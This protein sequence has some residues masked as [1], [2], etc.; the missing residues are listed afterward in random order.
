MFSQQREYLME[1]ILPHKFQV[2]Q[3]LEEDD[4][5]KITSE[6]LFNMKEN[7]YPELYSPMPQA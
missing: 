1:K 2:L 3:E 4:Q 7:L 6:S 5:Q